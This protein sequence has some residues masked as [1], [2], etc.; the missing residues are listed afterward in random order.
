MQLPSYTAAVSQ[1]RR[2]HMQRRVRW[3][4]HTHSAGYNNWIYSHSGMWCWTTERE[5]HTASIAYKI[6]VYAHCPYHTKLTLD[7]YGQWAYE[8][9]GNAGL[10]Y[11]LSVVGEKNMPWK[12]R[13][14]FFFLFSFLLSSLY[15]PWLHSERPGNV[16]R[17][18]G[19][20]GSDA[21]VLASAG[22]RNATQTH[23]HG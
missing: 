19:W 1:P 14:F 15:H 10:V 12:Y 17:L 20:W 9:A 3:N 6:L 23:I 7:A 21:F 5:A 18:N 4:T 11:V 22:Y 16:I 2:E 8:V 13:K